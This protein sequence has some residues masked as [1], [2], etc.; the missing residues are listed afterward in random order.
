MEASCMLVLETEL[1]LLGSRMDR[2]FVKEKT[3]KIKFGKS[4]V[5]HTVIAC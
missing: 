5:I 2:K 1:L 4:F 3:R